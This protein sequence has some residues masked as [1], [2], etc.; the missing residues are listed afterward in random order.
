[1]RQWS[2][3][4]GS[5]GQ[6][7]FMDGFHVQSVI[8]APMKLSIALGTGLGAVM[9]PLDMIPDMISPFE[10][11][12]AKLARKLVITMN[13]VQVL[14]ES[15]GTGQTFAAFA[16]YPTSIDDAMF[17]VFQQRPGQL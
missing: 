9:H 6:L 7:D 1:M 4:Y 8:L 2:F 16:A 10:F 11:Q 5:I 13:R 12:R 14:V 15:K 3:A 17:A